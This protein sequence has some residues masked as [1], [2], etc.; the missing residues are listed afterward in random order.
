MEILFIEL[1]CLVIDYGHAA[2]QCY[3]CNNCGTTW[4]PSR[5][6]LAITEGGANYCTVCFYDTVDSRRIVK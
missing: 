1:I 2:F 4:D 3:R 5:A 6:V